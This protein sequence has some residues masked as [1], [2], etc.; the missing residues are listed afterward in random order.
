[1]AMP[2]VAPPVQAAGECAAITNVEQRLVCI[3]QKVDGILSP[4]AGAAAP[5]GAA[6]AA[7]APAAAAGPD[8]GI[9]GQ[10]SCPTDTGG[11]VC[12]FAATDPANCGALAEKCAA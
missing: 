6:P 2:M 10:I 4:A 1:L 12:T 11:T 8:C 9:G 3:E 7:A 5:A